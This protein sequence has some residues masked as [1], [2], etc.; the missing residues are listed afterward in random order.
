M[1]CGPLLYTLNISDY[2]LDGFGRLFEKRTLPSQWG[3]AF[4]R[5]VYYGEKKQTISEASWLKCRGPRLKTPGMDCTSSK[6]QET[7]NF[8]SL[9]CLQSQKN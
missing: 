2:Q 1:A 8:Y 6:L 3:S 9:H 4:I 7:Q 5:D